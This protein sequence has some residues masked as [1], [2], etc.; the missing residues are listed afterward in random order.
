M[1]S[2]GYQA[3]R[4]GDLGRRVSGEVAYWLFRLLIPYEIPRN[5]ITVRLMTR[6]YV[7]ALLLHKE[8]MTAIGG[9]WVITGFRQKGIAVAK[10]ERGG[11][12]LQ[13]HKALVPS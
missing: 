9:L 10:G 5:H 12:H 11:H 1:S 2:T 6:P 4:A 13:L 7:D 3:L 8:Q